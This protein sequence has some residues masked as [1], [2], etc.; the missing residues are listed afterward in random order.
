MRI[1][2]LVALAVALMIILCSSAIAE[3]T[4]SA[5]GVTPI[6][7]E[8]VALTI[9]V[10]DDV[11]VEDYETNAQ[12]LMLEEL[13]NYDIQFMVLSS[14]DYITKLNMMVQSGD[15]LPDIIFGTES[16]YP[17]NEMVYS[18]ALAGAL[19][20]LTEYI[21][22]PDTAYYFTQACERTGMDMISMMTMPDGEI[23]YLPTVNQSY[24]NAAPLK[25]HIYTP[26][27]E[28]LGKEAPAT[29]DELYELLKAA[30]GID[31]NGNGKADEMGLVGTYGDNYTSV[32]R[33]LMNA[34]VYAG[35]PNYY[36]VQDGTVGFAYT[37][38]AWKEGLKYIRTLFA[39][40]LIPSTVLTMDSSQ[41]Q[42]L[43][44]QEENCAFIFLSNWLGIFSSG[45]PTAQ[46]CG[47]FTPVTGPD[48]VCYASYSAV[49]PKATFLVTADCEYPEAAFRLGDLMLSKDQ[50]II[51][52]WGL[53]GSDWEYYEKV[54]NK[55]EF[56]SAY[57]DEF[58]MSIC[59]F[60]A[61]FWS[62]PQNSSLRQNGPFIRE[63]SIAAGIAK[64]PEAMTNDIV[65]NANS[66]M[67]YN[68]GK[69][70]PAESIPVLIFN[71]EELA[72]VNDKLTTLTNRVN[73]ETAAFLAGNLD[74]D[75]EWENFQAELKAIGINEVLEVV[76]GV[77][78]RMY[79]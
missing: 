35:D 47:F 33:A 14:T 23:Y 20:P 69:Y 17:S 73:E 38:D 72:A 32:V 7:S 61:S 6:C 12:T 50:S 40:D 64:K 43:L 30:K 27:L 19:A 28:Q 3:V 49:A 58:D 36:T 63:Y 78:N 24:A 26:W 21:R 76:Q 71:D 52:R 75:S 67:A 5:G 59:T 53:E 39:E 45:N 60:N 55:D 54:E 57:T 34:F 11:N 13:G 8:K 1:R 56:C 16:M 66:Q 46:E 65:T 15:K 74:I 31:F 79:K 2:K 68:S 41:Y 44:N 42:T 62:E 4:L 10:P 25:F 29:T 9:A 48:G 70:W 18:W 51:T 22:N 77:Y 37:T